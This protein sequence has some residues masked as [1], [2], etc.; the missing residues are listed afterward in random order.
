M[1]LGCLSFWIRLMILF[2]VPLSLN[3]YGYRRYW[4]LLN[5][6]IP[7]FLTGGRLW[8]LL[9]PASLV[10]SFHAPLFYKDHPFMGVQRQPPDLFSSC[11]PIWIRPFVYDPHLCHSYCLSDKLHV[12]QDLDMYY[13]PTDTPA[14]ARTSNLN[15][16]LGQIKYIFSDKT[17][18]LTRN[19]ME[20]KQC[21][22]AGIRY[23]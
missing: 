16:E 1:T 22:I 5:S 9:H 12:T 14:M 19:E 23:E 11:P 13:A 20:F 3:F 4:R 21:S 2:V 15:E 18:T 10:C 6:S 7:W 17:G 8:I